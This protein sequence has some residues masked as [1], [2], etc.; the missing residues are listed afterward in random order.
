MQTNDYENVV[1]TVLDQFGQ[2]EEFEIQKEKRQAA[3]K[4][5]MN[6]YKKKMTQM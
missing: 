3:S 6:D 1:N 5:E 2:D 4:K